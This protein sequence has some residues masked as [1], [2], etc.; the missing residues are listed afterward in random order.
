MTNTLD[1]RAKFEQELI[2]QQRIQE[3]LKGKQR[4]LQQN[5]DNI[6]KQIKIWKDLQVKSVAQNANTLL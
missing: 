4:N 6:K 1:K 5:Q 2:Q 3:E